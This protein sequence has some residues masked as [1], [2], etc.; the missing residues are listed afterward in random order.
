MKMNKNK[1]KLNWLGSVLVLITGL[2]QIDFAQAQSPQATATAT[3][4]PTPRPAAYYGTQLQFLKKLNYPINN[5]NLNNCLGAISSASPNGVK[6]DSTG[7]YPAS[8]FQCV[9]ASAPA[10]YT[11]WSN[12]LFQNG[13]QITGFYTVGG[14]YCPQNQVADANCPIVVRTFFETTC[15]NNVA[16]APTTPLASLSGYTADGSGNL[17]Q[18]NS[19]PYCA[20]AASITP[21]TAISFEGPAA[22]GVT[23]F[24][25]KITCDSQNGTFD[26]KTQITQQGAIQTSA[27]LATTATQQSCSTM[28]SGGPGFV[29][30]GVNSDGSPICQYDPALCQTAVSNIWTGASDAIVPAPCPQNVVIKDYPLWNA[31]VSVQGNGTPPYIYTVNQCLRA[32]TATQPTQIVQLD[33]NNT[34][35][36]KAGTGWSYYPTTPPS[37]GQMAPGYPLLKGDPWA[38][39][40]NSSNYLT[41]AATVLQGYAQFGGLVAQSTAA[42]SPPSIDDLL[43]AENP[44][45]QAGGWKNKWP[46]AT[47]TLDGS[48]NGS[49][50]TQTSFRQRYNLQPPPQFV[51]LFGNLTNQQPSL[52]VSQSRQP[53]QKNSNYGTVSLPDGTSANIYL[54]G[55]NVTF[56]FDKTY[57]QNS[58]FVLLVGGGNS[59]DDGNSSCGHTGTAG[60][61]Y[62]QTIQ[63]ITEGTSCAFT[64]G[65]VSQATSLSCTGT[66]INQT[67]IPG[68]SHL[69]DGNSN[70]VSYTTN[71]GQQIVLGTSNGGGYGAG[72]AEAHWGGTLGGCS[73]ANPGSPG[74]AAAW[75][76]TVSWCDQ[77]FNGCQVAAQV[78]APAPAPAPQPAPNP[79][80]AFCIKNPQSP[81]C[82]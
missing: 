40:V 1:K 63:G 24:S 30:I 11:S 65:D 57:W 17:F 42:P 39:A 49:L 47:F 6:P 22:P 41:T 29:Q 77:G 23:T 53:S 52:A 46:T 12:T 79:N 3:A 10:D 33:Q 48:A 28:S 16:N 36:W 78:Q 13:K 27:I 44:N 80:A 58:L 55:D 67:A 7:A 50:V 26:P 69:S 81:R 31:G 72:G 20:Y 56:S 51:C 32:G 34:Y 76:Q 60:Q 54:A 15:P 59:A 82:N 35:G 64:V 19:G 45:Y 25:P 62:A 43:T 18:G 73:N 75:W 66:I 8:A 37:V 74:M 5:S 70:T 71:G 68:N 21:C 4:T 61:V 38:M 2:A 9:Q 14:A